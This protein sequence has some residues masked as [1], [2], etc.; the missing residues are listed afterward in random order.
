[1]IRG[2]CLCGANVLELDAPAGPVTACHCTQCRKYSGHH[3]ASLDVDRDAVRWVKQGHIKEFQHPS[4]ARRMFCACC[5]TKLWFEGADGWFS[6]EAGVLD[7]PTG[8]QMAGHIFVANKGD[9]YTISD[10][11]PQEAYL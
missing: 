8:G 3:A 9:Y 7:A 4:G 2:S 11:L 5:G 1:M 6:L 10:S